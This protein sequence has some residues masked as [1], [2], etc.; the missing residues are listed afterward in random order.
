MVGER[1]RWEEW[2]D[3]QLH[4]GGTVVLA[5]PVYP[6]ALAELR[7]ACGRMRAAGALAILVGRDR[8]PATWPGDP[9][10]FLTVRCVWTEGDW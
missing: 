1:K 5:H 2:P 7:R 10:R 3:G 4:D 9:T 6:A 8:E